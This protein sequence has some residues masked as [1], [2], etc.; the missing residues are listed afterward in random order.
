MDIVPGPCH[1]FICA[2][3]GDCFENQDGCSGHGF[4]HEKVMEIP[5]CH[6]IKK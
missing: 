6:F 4:F 2:D 3:H 1:F 5:M